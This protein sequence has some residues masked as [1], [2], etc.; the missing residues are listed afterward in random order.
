MT[1][2][3]IPEPE[4][5]KHTDCS[6]GLS[7][8]CK[9]CKAAIVEKAVAAERERCAKIADELSLTASGDAA[10]GMAHAIACTIRNTNLPGRG[11]R[12]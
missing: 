6:A 4:A 2:T 1:N 7:W 9:E 8:V 10:G 3:P 12:G 5:W 11:L